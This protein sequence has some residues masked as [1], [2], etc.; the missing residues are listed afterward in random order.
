VNDDTSRP[1][2]S[3]RDAANLGHDPAGPH[4]DAGDHPQGLGHDPAPGDQPDED[5]PAPRDQPAA[6]VQPSGDEL[7]LRNLPWTITDERDSRSLPPWFRRAVTLVLVLAVISRVAVWAFGELTS[8]WYTIFVAFFAGLTLEPLVNRMAARGMRRGLATIVAIVGLGAGTVG[9]FLIFGNLLADQLA[10]FISSIPGTIDE[11]VTWVNSRFGTTFRTGTI[12]KT[13]GVGTNDIAKAA[14]NVGVGLL[15][16]L[17][18]AIGLVFNLFTVALFAFYFAADGPR[19]RRTLAAWLPP[20]QQRTFLTVWDIATQKAGGYVI[21]RGILAIISATFH[22]VVFLLLDLPYWL[23]LALWV[24]LVSQFIPT[25]GTYLAGALPILVAL[26]NGNTLQAVLVLVAVIAYQQV[27]NYLVSPHVTQSTLEIHPA[28]AFGSVIVGSSLFGATGALLA[29]P[30]V[31]TIQ[32]LFSVYGR[33]YDLVSE[34]GP[35]PGASDAERVQAVVRA[36][37]EGFTARP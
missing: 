33:R 2:P 8:F 23:P 37:G 17:S 6:G 25:I 20:R 31:A 13:L 5:Q 18:T 29:I 19:F 1:E 32:A 35:Q 3:R 7:K 14:A 9:F 4:P 21:S 28:V 24:G 22:G 36:E 27:E 12:L 11:V 34:F 30:V 15:S 10:Q 16:L 26:V